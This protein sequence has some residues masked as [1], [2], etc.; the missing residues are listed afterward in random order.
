MSKRRRKGGARR[1]TCIPPHGPHLDLNRAEVSGLT[2]G[3]IFASFS[4]GFLI[5]WFHCRF[6]RPKN[7]EPERLACILQAR[8]DADPSTL[9]VLAS[10]L[11]G[12]TMAVRACGSFAYYRARRFQMLCGSVE[13]REDG[14]PESSPPVMR[15]QDGATLC[16]L[17]QAVP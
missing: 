16:G 15:W 14:A 10:A 7:A 6:Q 4:Q 8:I 11:N 5:F 17:A 3:E 2:N 12:A 1:P 13:I 9:A